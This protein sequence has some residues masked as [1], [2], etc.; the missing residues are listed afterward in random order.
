MCK[1]LTLVALLGL[2][3][4]T[5]C[6]VDLGSQSQDLSI[7]D[8]PTSTLHCF[9]MIGDD[10][11]I[12][13]YVSIPLGSFEVNA[14]DTMLEAE[15]DDSKYGQLLAQYV[16]AQLN[17]NAGADLDE[18]DIDTLVQ[19]ED[20][21]VAGPTPV[22]HGFEHELTDLTTAIA[23]FNESQAM[24]TPCIKTKVVGALDEVG[25][26]PELDDSP[27]N[28]VGPALNE[29]LVPEFLRSH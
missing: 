22:G 1:N 4:V 11:V 7:E 17:V 28:K 26:R 2:S 23:D 6:A 10:V 15:A 25:T 21:L 9:R 8:L 14:A 19:A 13:P 12:P 16:T 29:V 5:G 20:M 24:E 18:S 27:W 3:L